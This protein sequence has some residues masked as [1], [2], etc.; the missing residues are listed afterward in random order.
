[1]EEK[2]K[3]LDILLSK[4]GQLNYYQFE[5]TIL[6]LIQLITA[7][8]F[9]QCLPFLERAPYVFINNSSESVPIN[10]KICKETNNYK[11]DENKLPNSI[12]MDFNIYCEKFKIIGLRFMVFLGMIIGV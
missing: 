11:L 2:N 1:M 9:N 3:K 8:F 5:V 7:E 4:A 10:Y 6:F 12:V